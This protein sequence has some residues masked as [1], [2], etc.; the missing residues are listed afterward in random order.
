MISTSKFTYN[1]ET[2]TFSAE[3]SDLGQLRMRQVYPDACDE[4]FDLVSHRTGVSV[5]VVH[6]HTEKRDGD[7]LWD[8]FVPVC[9]L[10]RLLFNKVVIFND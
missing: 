1:P 2:K 9:K 5:V 6:N 3:A 4:G 7:V 10:D 8:E